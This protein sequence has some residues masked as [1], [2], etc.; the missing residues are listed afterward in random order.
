MAYRFA[1]ALDL[2]HGNLVR[3][4]EQ[5]AETRPE[6]TF[7]ASPSAQ[8]IHPGVLRYLVEVGAADAA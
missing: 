4:V 5:G 3:R 7:A 8:Q 2:G 1:K 6:N